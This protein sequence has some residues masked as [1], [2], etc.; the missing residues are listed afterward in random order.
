MN[1]HSVLSRAECLN[2]MASARVGRLVYTDRALPAVVPLR[3]FLD[4]EGVLVPM[5]ADSALAAA[6]HNTVVAFHAD[7]LDP[8]TLTG[9]SVTVIGQARPVV[10]PA[11][12][13]RLSSIHCL[14]MRGTRGHFARISL[15]FVSGGRFGAMAGESAS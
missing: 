11:E 10:G 13:A 3:F 4:G 2:L 1:G 9:W 6:I 8:V 14:R 12:I 15:G 5:G 7:D